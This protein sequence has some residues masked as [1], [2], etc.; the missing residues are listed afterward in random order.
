M[1]WIDVN[2]E[3]PKT[4]KKLMIFDSR[5]NIMQMAY[6]DEDG[7]WGMKD[8]IPSKYVTHWLIPKPPK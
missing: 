2:K 5:L 1:T 4:K 7:F 8:I 3:L 6:H